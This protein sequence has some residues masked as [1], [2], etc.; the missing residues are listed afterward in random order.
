MGTRGIAL[1][2]NVFSLDITLIWIG[3]FGTSSV[4]SCDTRG[5]ENEELIPSVS[6]HAIA[7]YDFKDSTRLATLGGRREGRG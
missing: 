2:S 5:G 3:L 7:R 1:F 6:A 4:R